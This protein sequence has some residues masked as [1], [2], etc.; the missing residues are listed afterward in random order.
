M[1]RLGGLLAVVVVGL[2]ACGSSGSKTSTTASTAAAAS[3]SAS[4]GAASNYAPPSGGSSSGG[5]SVHLTGNFCGDGKAASQ[6]QAFT[7]QPGA[8]MEATMQHDLTQLQKLASEAPSEIKPDVNTILNAYAQ[9]VHGLETANDN[10]QAME[11][12]FAPLQAEA[13]QIKAASQ[14]IE[15]YVQAH[16]GVTIG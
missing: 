16:C 4:T 11:Q 8:N 2:V 14:R 12:A 5:G 1:R 3:G 10:P 13:P 7:P 6:D 9:L 15:A